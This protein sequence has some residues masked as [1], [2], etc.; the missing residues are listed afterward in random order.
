MRNTLHI[1]MI[2]FLRNQLVEKPIA[3]ESNA[4]RGK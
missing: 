1:E 2:N 4:Y 3:P